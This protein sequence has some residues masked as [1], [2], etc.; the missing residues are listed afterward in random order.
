MEDKEVTF[1]LVNDDKYKDMTFK[2]VFAMNSKR[3]FANRECEK[4]FTKK[5]EIIKPKEN[6]KVL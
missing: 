3:F 5:A 4:D 1:K 6:P 2:E